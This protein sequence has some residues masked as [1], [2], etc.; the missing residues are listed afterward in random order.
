MM[1]EL[2]LGFAC[3]KTLQGRFQIIL[4]AYPSLYATQFGVSQVS[5]TEFV[6]TL[7]KKLLPDLIYGQCKYGRRNYMISSGETN[8]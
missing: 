4:T 7:V 2:L 8:L 5:L 6:E 3:P 1:L